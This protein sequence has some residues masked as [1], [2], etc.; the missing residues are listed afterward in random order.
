MAPNLQWCHT[1]F[2]GTH[3]YQG[4]KEVYSPLYRFIRTH[5]DLFDSYQNHPQF[6]LILPYRNYVQNQS[7]WFDLT[8][9]IASSNFT[10]EIL[11]S[12]DDIVPHPLELEKI[13][14][15]PYILCPTTELMTVADQKTIQHIRSSTSII[16][17]FSKLKTVI[18]PLVLTNSGT[19]V[20]FFPR[21][22]KDS[23]VIHILNNNYSPS[24]DAFKVIKN[25]EISLKVEELG[26]QPNARCQVFSP[27]HETLECEMVDGTIEIPE[28]K[29][30]SILKISK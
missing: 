16:K 22:G 19:D 23:I 3:W 14:R 29:L 17:E 26:L 21:E 18:Q 24:E 20:R 15:H 5:Q 1:D 28:L 27:D 7:M 25:L 11:L 6:A 12:G 10:F 9:E 4:P 8:K 30:W 2:L 13:N